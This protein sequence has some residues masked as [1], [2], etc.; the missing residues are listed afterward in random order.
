MPKKLRE[1][2]VWYIDRV[3]AKKSTYIP[4]KN[5]DEAILII[6][7]LAERDLNDERITDNAMGLE[8]KN[9]EEEWEEYM[10]KKT[11]YEISDI[12]EEI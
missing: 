5:I 4:V 11:G 10:D 2:R 6:N 1:L 8:E 7:A 12:M 9:E 3:P